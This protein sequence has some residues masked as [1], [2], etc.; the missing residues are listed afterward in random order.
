MEFLSLLIK[1]CES[2]L[3]QDS[4]KELFKLLLKFFALDTMLVV[5]YWFTLKRSV[6][7]QSFILN[8]F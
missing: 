3:S 8:A 4:R 5:S 7:E 1:F 2:C 6:A